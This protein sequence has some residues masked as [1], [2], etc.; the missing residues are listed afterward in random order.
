MDRA[1]APFGEQDMLAA[2]LASA[3]RWLDF[4]R[5]GLLLSLQN[6]GNS[7]RHKR[8]SMHRDADSALQSRDSM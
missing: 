2:A 6:N 3:V 4:C 1:R 8:F 7:A 5:H